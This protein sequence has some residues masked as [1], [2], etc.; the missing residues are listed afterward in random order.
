MLRK[1]GELAYWRKGEESQN[2][3]DYL[4][5]YLARHL[6]LCPARDATQIRLVGSFLSDRIIED[7]YQ[8]GGD[9]GDGHIAPRLLA[10]GGGIREAGGLSTENLEAI[11]FLAAST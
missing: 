7:A 9:A 10:W 3:G 6:F 4:N 8:A 5:E 1:M 2:F 11:F